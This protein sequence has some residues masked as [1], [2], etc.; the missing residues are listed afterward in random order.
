[1][2]D[3]DDLN[4]HKRMAMGGAP[5]TGNFGVE[6]MADHAKG[7]HVDAGKMTHRKVNHDGARGASKPVERGAA[8][9][10]AQAAPD[11][12]PTNQ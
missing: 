7:E 3:S 9:N 6:A 12:G 11:H 5:D 8:M 4:Q 1:M 10:P 2:K